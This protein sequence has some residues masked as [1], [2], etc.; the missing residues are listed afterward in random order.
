M[1]QHDI[2]N[3]LKN[4]KTWRNTKQIAKALGVNPP[5][6]CSSIRVMIRT[7]MVECERYNSGKGNNGHKYKVIGHKYKV[8]K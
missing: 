4:K 8:K 2:Y 7:G 6:I 5:T 1:A 3:Y